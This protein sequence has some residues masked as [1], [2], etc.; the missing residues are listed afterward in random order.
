MASSKKFLRL[1]K[2]ARKATKANQPSKQPAAVKAH[3]DGS[4]KAGE[5]SYKPQT[6]KLPPTFAG[7]QQWNEKRYA[8][9]VSVHLLI[10]PVAAS[11]RPGRA[12]LAARSGRHQVPHRLAHVHPPGPAAVAVRMA[13]AQ[14]SL[15]G[16]HQ[17]A[18]GCGTGR[19][20]SGRQ[21]QQR[22]MTS[23]SP[24]SQ[25][26]QAQHHRLRGWP[27]QHHRAAC[28]SCL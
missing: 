16:S 2:Q 28:S 18:P 12:G 11:C 15:W 23:A 8:L 25:G 3:N 6:T 4:P 26:P 13:A 20:T 14:Y 22:A 24:S 27:H 1:S 7:P 19:I 10:F 21:L 9:E 5:P 17:S